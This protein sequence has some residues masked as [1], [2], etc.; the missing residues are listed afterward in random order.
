VKNGQN[1]EGG[2]GPDRELFKK[3]NRTEN[4]SIEVEKMAEGC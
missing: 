3:E 4:R 1:T 2:I